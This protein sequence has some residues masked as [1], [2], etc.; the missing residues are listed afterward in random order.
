LSSSNLV[1]YAHFKEFGNTN[2]GD[3][4][5]SNEKKNRDDEAEAA[6]EK[7]ISAFKLI[8]DATCDVQ[9]TNTHDCG[10][11]VL[12]NGLLLIGNIEGIYVIKFF[13]F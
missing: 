11:H 5:A 4:C 1:K 3:G 9:Q 7:Y 10:I 13:L 6:A 12:V 2:G 8:N